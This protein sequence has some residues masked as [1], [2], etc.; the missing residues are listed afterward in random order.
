MK[1]SYGQSYWPQ[2]GS[3]SFNTGNNYLVF[4]CSPNSG[5]IACVGDDT[6]IVCNTDSTWSYTFNKLILTNPEK[7]TVVDNLS[8]NI[9]STSNTSYIYIVIIIIVVLCCIILGIFFIK[10]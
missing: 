2:G 7:F 1:S 5:L 9:E 3:I 8:T 10:K 4:Q 6:S